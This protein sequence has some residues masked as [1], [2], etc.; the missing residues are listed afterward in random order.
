MPEI[1]WIL[2]YF[3]FHSLLMGLIPVINMSVHLEAKKFTFTPV[4]VTLFNEHD[5]PNAVVVRSEISSNLISCLNGLF[6]FGD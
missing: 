6:F 4:S 5:Y 3:A 2:F 1:I